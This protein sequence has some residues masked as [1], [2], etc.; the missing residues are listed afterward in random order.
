[1]I[2]GNSRKIPDR[3]IRASCFPVNYRARGHAEPKGEVALEEFE[4]E[5]SS[6]DVVF[7]ARERVWIG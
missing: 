4:V 6:F 5:A 1:M 3:R 7:K 2:P